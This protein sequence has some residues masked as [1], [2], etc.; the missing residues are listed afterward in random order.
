MT[1]RQRTAITDNPSS[2]IE[3][4][5][6]LP[7][8]FVCSYEMKEEMYVSALPRGIIIESILAPPHIS[9]GEA[10]S[11]ADTREPLKAQHVFTFVSLHV[12][13]TCNRC[14]V[15]KL[16]FLLL[17]SICVDLS[18]SSPSAYHLPSL[19]PPP[20]QAVKLLWETV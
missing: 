3:V 2:V 16:L 14:I 1:T 9:A 10:L 13:T 6:L 11:N 8:P 7:Q 18:T 5:F 20:L 19:S 4:V 15:Q 12:I 17:P